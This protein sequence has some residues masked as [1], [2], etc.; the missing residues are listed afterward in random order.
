MVS[1]SESLPLNSVRRAA[2]GA[3]TSTAIHWPWSPVPH[4]RSS[5]TGTFG[6]P[7]RPRT[8]VFRFALLFGCAVLL[9]LSN[10]E[11]APASDADRLFESGLTWDQFLAGATAQRDAWLKT[12]ATANAP[13]DL[14]ERFRRVSTGLRLLV[15]AEDWCPD[16]VNVVPHIAG[17][18]SSVSVPLRIVGRKLGEP[19]LDKHRTPDGR[20]ATPTIVLLREGVEADDAAAWIERPAVIQQWFRSMAADSESARRFADRQSWYESDHGRTALAEVIALAEET[21]AGR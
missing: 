18:A 12:T 10:I 2:A 6:K 1:P 3:A 11:A 7:V 9:G 17:L 4:L 16:S 21:A 14:I 8:P 19:L 20:T 15:V 13:Q 5:P